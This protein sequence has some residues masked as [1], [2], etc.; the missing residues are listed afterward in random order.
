MDVNSQYCP[1]RRD[2]EERS[3]VLVSKLAKLSSQLLNLLGN[4][5][6]FAETKDECAHV[7]TEF[8]ELAQ[9]LQSHRLL[10]RC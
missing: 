10:H 2:I 9:R 3:W 6:A 8:T 4:H 1:A 7:R 5:Q